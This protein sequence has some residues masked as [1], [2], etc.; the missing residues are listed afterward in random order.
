MEKYKIIFF[1][2]NNEQWN[3]LM[4]YLQHIY[5]FPEKIDQAAVVITSSAILS[6]LKHSDQDALH[7]EMEAYQKKGVAFFICGNT[8]EKFQLDPD[9]LMP[10]MDIVSEGGIYKVLECQSLG[11]SLFKL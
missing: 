3:G 6:C 4:N 2:S 11:Y 8:V 10:D 7:R 5:L 9:N 1:L